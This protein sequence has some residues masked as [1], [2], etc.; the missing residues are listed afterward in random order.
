MHTVED[1]VQNNKSRVRDYRNTTPRNIDIIERMHGVMTPREMGVVPWHSD[2]GKDNM[3]LVNYIDML[4][5][6]YGY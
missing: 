3:G 2:L 6:V 5:C 4:S 1:V